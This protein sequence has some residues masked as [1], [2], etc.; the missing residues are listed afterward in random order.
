MNEKIPLLSNPDYGKDEDGVQ[1]KA[2]ICIA[3]ADYLG[4]RDVHVI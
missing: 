3:N 4:V 1:V 2:N